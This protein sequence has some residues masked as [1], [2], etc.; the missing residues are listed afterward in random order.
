MKI[1]TGFVS[2]SSSSSFVV[3]I[4]NKTTKEQLK[5]L[6]L[7]KYKD[8]IIEFCKDG[9]QYAY[10]YKREQDE[11]M[12]PSLEGEELYSDIAERIARDLLSS[13]AGQYAGF[14][15]TGDWKTF[16][17]EVSSEADDVSSLF[18]YQHG[19]I[20]SEFLKCKSTYS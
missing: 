13:T 16:A 14:I 1:R 2:N 15:E 11:S 18:L 4:K 7:T 10:D 12:E 17:T 8:R 19:T 9:L 5:S 6:L 20:D 3:G